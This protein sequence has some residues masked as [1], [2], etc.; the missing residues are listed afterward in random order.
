MSIRNSGLVPVTLGV[1]IPLLAVGASAQEVDDGGQKASSRATLEEVV[2]TAQR[3]EEASVDV[4]ITISTLDSSQLTSNSVN[5]LSGIQKLTPGLRFDFAGGY[6]QPTIRGVGTPVTSVGSGGNVG[7]YIDGFY[8]PNPLSVNFDLVNVESIQVLKGPQGTLFGRNTTGGAILV[9]T[10]EPS[11]E[12]A[13]QLKASYGRYNEA[14]LQGY[15]THALTDRIAFDAEGQY[16]SGDGW[17]RNISNGQRVGDYEN[18]SVRLGLLFELSDDID[19]LLRY[20]HEE[21]DDPSPLLAASYRDSQLGSGEP[22]YAQPSEYTFSRNKIATGT[23]PSDQEKYRSDADIVQLTVRANLGF[24][25]FT[26]NS[27]YRDQYVD[28]N[29]D[30]DYSGVEYLE[31]GLPTDDEVWT[32]EFL[33]ASATESPLQWTA[34]LFYFENTNVFENYLDFFPLLGIQQRDKSGQF[35]SSAKVISSAAFLDATYE[36]VP[37]L[38]LTAGV[39][40]SDDKVKDLYAQC[41]LVCPKVYPTPEQEDKVNGDHVTPRFVARYE[42]SDQSNVYASYT[43]GYKAAIYD[44]GK[45]APIPVEPEKIDAYEVGY[46]YG[47]SSFSLDLSAFYYDYKNLQ[48]S[49]YEN[50]TATILNAADSEIYGMDGQ[51]NYVVNDNVRVN[52]GANWTHA[53]YKQFDNAPVYERCAPEG[54][55]GLG[56]LDTFTIAAQTLTDVDMQRAPAFTANLGGVYTNQLWGGEFQLS[57]NLYYTS[58]FYFGPS[59][60]QFKQDAYEVLSIRA[61]WTEPGGTYTYAIWGDNLTDNRYMTQVQY[62][63]TGIGANWSKPVTYGVEISARF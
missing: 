43:E 17:Q 1:A 39:R 54:S 62:G 12:P 45:G 30:L 8:S 7:I 36:V 24:A 34:G 10:S 63:L 6:Y 18:W 33:L 23:H 29:L 3:R 15:V 44:V 9:Q 47:G 60:T 50:G 27:Q 58:S 37:D 38:F 48:V 2:V 49:L 28:S 19:V 16:R 11:M 26:S 57:G 35:G 21:V 25:N 32:Q 61:Q 31:F 22:W 53:R 14:K 56:G 4:P 55:C 41:A 51:L 42:T 40:Y 20:Q 5:A 59:G 13:A 46:K 52:L